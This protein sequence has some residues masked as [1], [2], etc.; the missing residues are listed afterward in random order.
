GS[1][2]RRAPGARRERPHHARRL[3]VDHL[4]RQADVAVVE[5]D[6]AVAAPSEQRA[7]LVVP[8]DHLGAE[9]HDEEERTVLRPSD[10]LVRDLDPVGPGGRHGW[11]SLALPRR[12][13]DAAIS[14]HRIETSRRRRCC[15][16]PSRAA[17]GPSWL[18]SCPPC[19]CWSACRAATGTPCWSFR[20]TWRATTPRGRC[21]PS[22]ATAATMR[23]PGAWAGTGARARTSSR[24]SRRRS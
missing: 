17:P 5:A 4:A 1:I 6:H 20:A 13:D 23:T 14:W 21:A 18:R 22:C 24:A 9:S 2:D 3:A 16:S 8:V 19:R 12:A 7:Q 15:C 11:R 10:H